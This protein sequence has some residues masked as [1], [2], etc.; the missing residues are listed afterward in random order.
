MMHSANATRE[1]FALVGYA[2]LGALIAV[3]VIIVLLRTGALRAGAASASGA[4]S[5]DAARSSCPLSANT[6]AC[7]DCMN[8]SC[9]A[10]C[11]ACAASG[12]CLRLYLCLLDCND[13]T[14]R[15]AC[16]KRYPD[17]KLALEAFAGASG[18]MAKQCAAACK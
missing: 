7:S 13:E 9:S 1:R 18:C 6:E 5:A 4:P 12:W 15:R 2:A 3:G 10:P 16:D 17:G 11:E 8:R 14:C